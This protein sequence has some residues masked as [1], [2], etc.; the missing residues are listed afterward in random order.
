M[1]KQKQI[2]YLPKEFI[3]RKLGK[4]KYDIGGYCTKET[5]LYLK[6]KIYPVLV[7]DGKRCMRSEVN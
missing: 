5:M 6:A 4:G 3:I 7:I 2:G 1:V